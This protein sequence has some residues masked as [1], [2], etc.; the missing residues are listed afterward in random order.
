M[1]KKLYNTWMTLVSLV[2][3]IIGL[4]FILVS[5]FDAGAGNS[6]LAIGLLFVVLGN[7]LNLVRLHRNRKVREE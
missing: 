2:L 7:L 6:V 1:D 3:A 4:T 5:V